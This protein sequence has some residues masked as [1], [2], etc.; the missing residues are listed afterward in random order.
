MDRAISSFL[1]PRAAILLCGLGTVAI[2]TA[3]FLL[4]PEFIPPIAYCVSVGLAAWTRSRRATWLVAAL[5]VALTIAGAS[6]GPATVYPQIHQYHI[7]FN[8][9]LACLAILA[10]AALVHLWILL[11]NAM[12]RSRI[13]LQQ[14][15]DELAAREEEIARQNEELQ[16]QTEEL[17]RQSEELRVANEELGRRERALQ[18]LLDLSRSLTAGLSQN[19]TLSRICNALSHL[20]NHQATASAILVHDGDELHIRCHSGFGPDG[21]AAARLP[22]ASSFGRLVMEKNQWGYIEDLSLRPDLVVPRPSQ[23]VVRS[24]LAAPLRVRGRAIGTLEVYSQDKTAWAEEQIALVESLAAQTSISLE[25]AGLFEE[26]DEQRRR[27]ETVIRTLPVG[28][29]VT[30]KLASDVRINAAGAAMLNLPTDANLA[31]VLYADHFQYFRDGRPL[32]RANYPLA[33]AGRGEVIQN[34]ELDLV[35]SSGRRA[36]LLVSAAP[37]RAREG[38]VEGALCAFTD[39]SD[40]KRLQHEIDQRRREAEEASVRKTRFLAAVSHDV[41]TPANA[42]SLMA[43]LI[44]RTAA[45]PAMAAEIP[46]MAGELHTSATR[47]VELVSDVL[48]VARFDTGRIELQETEFNLGALIT[49]EV[50]QLLPLAEEKKLLLE[51][52]LCDPP[53]QIRCDRIKLGRVIANLLANA[54]KFTQVGGVRVSSSLDVAGRPCIAVADT[55]IGI[56]PEHQPRVFDEFF[57]LRNPERDRNKGT[58]LGLAIVK[59]LIDAMGGQISLSSVPDKGSTFTVVLPNGCVIPQGFGA[60]PLPRPSREHPV[61]PLGSLRIL[62]VENHDDAL[63]ATSSLLQAQGAQVVHA[64]GGKEALERLAADQVDVLLLD[65]MLPDLSGQDLL[66]AI[67]RNRPSALKAI[68]VLTGD[69]AHLPHAQFE[70]L[71]V[72]A[73]CPKPIDISL[74]LRTISSAAAGDTPRPPV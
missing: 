55:G 9:A 63:R 13:E 31:G 7:L 48:D 19:E 44:R 50:R 52:D 39:I 3:D 6:I 47:L 46:S 27:F 8:R 11:I 22:F 56:P 20:I 49:D 4:P 28:V 2:A 12:Q 32:D 42:I 43:E 60:A 67:S 35:L 57:Q 68:I 36:S 51:I 59:R 29:M 74:L 62:L 14:Q 45:N 40:L 26:I 65:L 21:L 37:F 5:S 61:S 71:G 72:A 17:E 10:V 41:R 34:E 33:R 16:S 25:S 18:S 1:P 30:D 53:I 23:G 38:E 70:S 64:R 66:Q 54:I 58:G 24:V 69:L 15:N 73:I